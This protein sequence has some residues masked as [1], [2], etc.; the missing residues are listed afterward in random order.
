MNSEQLADWRIDVGHHLETLE[1]MINDRKILKNL[2]E[3]HLKSVFHYDDIEYNRDF[4]VITLKWEKHTNPIINHDA[5][6][7]FGM[8]WEIS[9]GYDDRAFSIVVVKVYPFGVTGEDDN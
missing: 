3:E 2:M 7:D 5:I 9:T 4:S 1:M 6:R 8:D